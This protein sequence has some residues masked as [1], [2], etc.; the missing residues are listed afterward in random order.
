MPPLL[1]E[2]HAP[3]SQSEIEGGEAMMGGL[4]GLVVRVWLCWLVVGLV[5]RVLWAG[6]LCCKP[7][8]YLLS[9]KAHKHRW[10]KKLATNGILEI[11][12]KLSMRQTK[13][14]YLIK[15]DL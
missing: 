12:R 11:A 14:L 2:A 10:A 9:C 7:L 1:T 5:V 4:C 15:A 3:H 8:R 13:L 6:C